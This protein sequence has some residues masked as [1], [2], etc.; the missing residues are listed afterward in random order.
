[1]ETALLTAVNLIIAVASLGLGT[2]KLLAARQHREWTLWLTAS[3][4]IFAGLIFLLATPLVYRFVGE[5]LHSANICALLVPA[6]TLTCVAHAH[7]LSQ[8]WQ[9]ER[10]EPA[11]LRRTAARWAPVYGGAIAAMTVL[12]V[13]ADLGPAT[14]LRF[15]AAYA[16]VPEVTALHAVYW[17]TLIVT[18]VVTVRE[19]RSVSIPGRPELVENVRNVLGWFALA[20]GL[21][22]VN[23]A[24]TAGAMLGS[25]TGPRRL[26]GLAESAW[27]ATIASCIAAQIALASL[28]LRSRREEHR[29]MRA[30]QPLHD[31]VIDETTD[32]RMI[33]AP[34]LP[35][36][37]GFTTGADLNDLMA[38]INDGTGRLSP[39]WNPMPALAVDRLAQE[40][41]DEPADGSNTWGGHWDLTAAHAA[42]TLLHAARAR[43]RGLP[44]LPPELRLARLPGTDIEPTDERQHL[45]RVARHLA[46]PLVSAAV[47]LTEE[48]QAATRAN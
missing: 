41:Q 10:R 26:D 34:R 22:L 8:L 17:T 12:Y 11:V 6:A 47:T 9:P 25:A 29:D 38:E 14:P 3:V 28:A 31:L 2:V 35:L 30:L 18:V 13:H 19:C 5:M 42:A 15:A 23:V 40:Q 48:T 1:M 21:D 27:L 7:A 24:L 32:H 46:H 4:L 39:W 44:H 20:L 37:T 45:V 16:H 36:W 33:L 43:S